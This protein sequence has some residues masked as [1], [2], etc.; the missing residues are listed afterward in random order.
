MSHTASYVKAS[1][2]FTDIVSNFFFVLIV[3][4]LTGKY[5]NHTYNFPYPGFYR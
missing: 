3:T 5:C 1:L 2:I 4:N